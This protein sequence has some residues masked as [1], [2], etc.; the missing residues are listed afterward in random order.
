VLADEL[1]GFGE[2]VAG[3]GADVDDLGTHGESGGAL[4]GGRVGGH[5]D[6]RFSADFAGG[7]GY[8]LG[9]IAAGVGDD[10]ASDS[11]GV[12]WRILLAAP[13]ILKAPMGWRD[14]ALR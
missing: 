14:S 9:V 2:A 6:D 12:S 5:D 4:D 13:R 8:A 3:C 1:V 10:A 11:S 7:V